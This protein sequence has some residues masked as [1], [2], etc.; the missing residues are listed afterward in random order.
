LIT[1]L[2]GGETL[3]VGMRQVLLRRASGNPFFLGELIRAL[4]ATRAL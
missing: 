3:P 1:H 4:Q 2:L